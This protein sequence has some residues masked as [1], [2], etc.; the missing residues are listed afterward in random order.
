MSRIL[1]EMIVAQQV[2]KSLVYYGILRF[3][4]VFIRSLYWSLY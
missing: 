4:A 3:I 2:K 1:E